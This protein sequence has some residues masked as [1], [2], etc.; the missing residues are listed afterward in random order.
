MNTYNC[1][2]IHDQAA[3]RFIDADNSFAARKQF[4]DEYNT[5]HNA[6]IEVHECVAIRIR[7][8]QQ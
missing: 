7:E 8:K 6:R 3:C 5:E 4:R 1:Y 2:W